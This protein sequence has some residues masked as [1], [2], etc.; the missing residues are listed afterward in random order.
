MFGVA[1]HIHHPRHCPKLNQEM[2]GL[3]LAKIQPYR[4]VKLLLAPLFLLVV[5]LTPT[6]QFFLAE[7]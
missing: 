6:A 4:Q 7:T 5:L 1:G 2:F 3:L